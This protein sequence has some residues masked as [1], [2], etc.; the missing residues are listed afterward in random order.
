MYLEYFGLDK[1]PFTISPDPD[2]LYPSPGHQEALAHL[3]YALSDQGGLICL[4]G[5]VGT[6][7]TTLCRALME[8]VPEG[9]HVAYIFNPQLS[10]I[11]LMQ[12]IC[13]DLG[14]TYDRDAT[15][16][17]IYAEINAALVGFYA[18]H[19]RVICVIDEAQSMPAALLEQ[20]RLLTNLETHREKLLT[21]VLVGQPELRELLKRH[22]LRQLNQRIT[23]RYHLGL[24]TEQE[25]GE[26]IE[27]RL[28]CAGSEYMLFEP[29]A[30]SIIWNSSDGTPR[31][32]NS[33]SDRALLGAYAT[34]ES[35]VTADIARRAV[36]E[37]MGAEQP[38]ERLDNTG[39]LPGLAA[40]VM[41]TARYAMLAVLLIGV[42]WLG[43]QYFPED[44]LMGPDRSDPVSVLSAST[45][46]Q[47]NSC[48]DAEIEGLQCI[49]VDWT[50]SELAEVEHPIAI[51]TT[52][53][54]WFA[55][56]EYD[57][58]T[59]GRYSEEAMILWNPPTEYVN[60]VKPGQTAPVVRWVRSKLG[61]SWDQ[62]WTTIGPGGVQVEMDPDYY[63]PLLERAVAEF[64]IAEGLKADR[65]I[66]PRTLM[67]LQARD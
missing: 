9:D 61:I 32:I 19:Q 2:F 49:Y 22:D 48:A 3:S 37:V 21:L 63:D 16:K 8:S 52:S 11:E 24:L 45:G 40:V 14:I 29:A 34:G 56:T 65:I 20:V 23:A 28:V 31:L 59:S 58:K 64:Q 35:V 42:A 51:K 7:K 17:E 54:E 53:G 13:D 67:Y 47:E 25:T 46:I 62:E 26:Y 1:L 57:R 39:G 55:L 10:P 27:H 66:G 50:L 41:K 60:A 33:I 38:E 44:T 5:E 18:R 36:T 12:S 15:L 30:V 6:G 43:Y 4:T